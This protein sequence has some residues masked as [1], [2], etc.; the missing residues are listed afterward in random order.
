VYV[1]GAGVNRATI[2]AKGALGALIPLLNSEDKY[3]KNFSACAIASLLED[4]ISFHRF[5][6][7]PHFSFL[8]S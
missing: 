7:G 5:D 2:L 6:A 1:C 4:G 8:F 3:P